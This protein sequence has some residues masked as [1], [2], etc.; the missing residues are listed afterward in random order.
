MPTLNKNSIKKE[1]IKTTFN[2]TSTASWHIVSYIQCFKLGWDGGK[3]IKCI[4]GD[5]AILIDWV[6]TVHAF[7]GTHCLMLS[8]YILS[9]PPGIQ[10]TPV[11]Q[12]KA[13]PKQPSFSF[14]SKSDKLNNHMA[15]C[16]LE[17][18]FFLFLLNAAVLKANGL[19]A[20]MGSLFR[21]ELSFF[22]EL[23]YY[24]YVVII[25]MDEWYIYAIWQW[26]HIY[27]ANRNAL[28]VRWIQVNSAS[29]IMF[30]SKTHRNI[31]RQRLY[32]KTKSN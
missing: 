15:F 17:T 7:C 8:T 30:S 28:W 26:I 6:F 31:L 2:I 11:M 4:W 3:V 12:I 32:I 14:S 16:K 20:H 24:L 25:Q 27:S 18:V 21:T 5:D 29:K 13:P 19:F 1:K 9:H 23:L 22:E 10:R